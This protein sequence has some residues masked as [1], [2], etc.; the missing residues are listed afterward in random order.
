MSKL[1]YYVIRGTFG[2]LIKS[3]LKERYQGVAIRDKLTQSIT[4]TGTC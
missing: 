2:T 4:H 1:E 3:Y